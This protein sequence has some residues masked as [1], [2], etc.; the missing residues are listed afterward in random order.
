MAGYS[1][2]SI[3]AYRN[4]AAHST[5]L[6]ADPYQLVAMLMD[7]ALERLNIARAA[8]Q[9]GDKAGKAAALHRSTAIIEELRS[10]LNHQVGGE[11]S[12]SLERLYDYMI[13]RLLAANLQ[14]DIKAID[15][16]NKLL[17][18]IR[19][20]WGAIPQAARNAKVP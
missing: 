14:D 11:I 4:V 8:I 13:R 9:R 1:N 2:S 10:S 5:V 7:T 3:A 16:V 17:S 12:S 20:G 19:G 15:E 18:E 6:E